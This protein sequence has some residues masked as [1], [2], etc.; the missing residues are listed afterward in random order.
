MSESAL[1]TAAAAAQESPLPAGGA[2]LIESV[3]ARDIFTYE[4]FSDD[5]L[6]LASTGEEFVRKEVLPRIDEIENKKD[7]SRATGSEFLHRSK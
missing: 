3:T 7:G 6:S 1:G 4:D 2:F 5:E